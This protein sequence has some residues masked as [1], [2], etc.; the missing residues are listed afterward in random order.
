MP[1]AKEIEQKMQSFGDVIFTMTSLC[2]RKLEKTKLLG[3]EK[4]CLKSSLIMF[5]SN[6]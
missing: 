6:I 5:F 3:E 1:E 4:N 2:A